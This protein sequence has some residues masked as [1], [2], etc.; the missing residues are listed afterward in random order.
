MKKQYI[1]VIIGLF[2]ITGLLSCNR[3]NPGH[4]V[5]INGL[6][7]GTY[8]A[9]TYFDHE[10]RDL[11]PEIDSFFKSFD[12]SASVY[13]ENSIISRINN[14]DPSVILDDS[15]IKVF[16]KSQEISAITNGAFDITTMPLTNAWG[17]GFTDP[18][19][20]DSAQVD[21]LLQFVDY[22]MVKVID[23]KFIKQKP[24]ITID[25]NAIAQGYS[26]DLIGKILDQKGITNYLI[27]V[28]G[29][30]LSKGKKPDGSL[31]KVG[32]EKPTATA[33]DP[34]SLDAIVNLEDKALASSGN[35]RRFFMKDGVKFSHTIDP[36]TGYPVM[37]TL[38]S[39]SVLGD[40]CMTA[41]AYA[42]AFMVMGVE[43][44][45]AFIGSHAGIEAHFIYTNSEGKYET[46]T[47]PGLEKL[48]VK[49]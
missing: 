28:G 44:A 21:S 29:E 36:K 11:Q 45:K 19:K 2:L 3:I 31:W 23:G 16:N 37:H 46:W 40:D 7:Q 5:K 22:R 4:E 38:L 9:I 41:D 32:I 39:V 43:K 30:V 17:F 12:K 8:Y 42:T 1:L 18:M 48:I 49:D 47:S 10:T 6:A 20:L 13:L 24:E 27:D 14:N 33:S 26:A 35:Y 25:Y 34:R 15:F